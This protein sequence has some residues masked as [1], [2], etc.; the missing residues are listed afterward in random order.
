MKIL[1][2]SSLLAVPLAALPQPIPDN[3][4]LMGGPCEG[5]EAVFEYG[6]R[7]LAPVDT[8]PDFHDEGPKIRISGTI[9]RPDGT[10]PAA[11]VILYVYHTDQ[12][13]IYPR[14][15]GDTGW[16]RRHGYIRGWVKTGK[17][18]RY[19]FYTLKPGTY[20]SRN[21]PAHIHPTILEPD[22]KYYWI[23]DFYFNDDP[24]LSGEQ[25][26]PRAPRGGTVGVLKLEEENGLLVGY[27][28]IVL[29]RNVPGY[30]E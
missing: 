20:P 28:D 18:G 9:Y 26:S 25:R 4:R 27:R 12:G 8:L 17:D 3:A 6:D 22:G 29:G 23:T 30:G 11:G 15:E 1:L 16:A 7:T 19:T 10:T 24:L 5:C 21:A 14:K 13:G 2:L